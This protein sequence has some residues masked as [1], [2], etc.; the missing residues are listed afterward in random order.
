MVKLKHKNS[1]D[2]LDAWY[3]EKM[4]RNS[5]PDYLLQGI[6]K[7]TS[8]GHNGGSNNLSHSAIEL[9]EPPANQEKPSTSSGA[10]SFYLQV[11]DPFYYNHVVNRRRQSFDI[12]TDSSSA[13]N[14]KSGISIKVCPTINVGDVNMFFNI[15]LL[16][17]FGLQ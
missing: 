15:R 8:P 3:D 16:E 2:G 5:T 11:P 9:G 13:S 1:L 4:R 7:Q 14:S 10:D 6:P 17:S 12:S